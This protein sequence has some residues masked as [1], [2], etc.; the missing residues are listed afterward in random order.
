MVR[1]RH[2]RRFRAVELSDRIAFEGQGFIH[3][4]RELGRNPV[5]YHPSPRYTFIRGTGVGLVPGS[6]QTLMTQPGVGSELHSASSQ[7]DLLGSE[8]L[9]NVP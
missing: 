3:L 8:I 5:P 6:N 7:N 4:L 2:G 9:R 1:S